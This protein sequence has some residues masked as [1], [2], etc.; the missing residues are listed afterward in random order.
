MLAQDLAGA[1]SGFV[2]LV[3]TA[4]LAVGA[5]T[6]T[7]PALMLVGIALVTAGSGAV[8]PRFLVERDRVATRD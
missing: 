2:P 8:A 6:S 5:G 7:L 1:V 3:A 4:L